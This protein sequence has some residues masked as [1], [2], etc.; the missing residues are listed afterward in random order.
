MV[1]GALKWGVG[2]NHHTG[3]E[4]HPRQSPRGYRPSP[5]L[6]CILLWEGRRLGTNPPFALFFH[7]DTAYARN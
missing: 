2:S 6:E 1:Q 4:R 7:F 5:R 3:T